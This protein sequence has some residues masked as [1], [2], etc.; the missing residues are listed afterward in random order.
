VGR[1]PGKWK[2][3]PVCD[4]LEEGTVLLLDF[5]KLDRVAGVVPCAVQDVDTG[6]VVL[7]AYVNEL[8][9]RHTVERRLATFWSTSRDELWVK[10]ATSGETFEVVE[11][12]VNC[13]QNSLLYMV[14]PRRAGICHSRS[15]DGVP[16]NCFYRR[17]EF[18]SM[19]LELLDP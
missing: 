8:A 2:N 9:L 13:E 5:K 11:I 17:V 18:D 15:R 12:R 7:V 6:E 14:R 19:R 16:R 3:Y 1:G 4:D 10:G